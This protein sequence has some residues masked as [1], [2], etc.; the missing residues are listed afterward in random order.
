MKNL[1]K[2]KKLLY[3][4]SILVCLLGGRVNAW[5]TSGAGH[6]THLRTYSPETAK[7][8]VYANT[9]NTANVTNASY[10]AISISES[11]QG[12]GEYK[13]NKYTGGVA[14]DFYGWAK[15]AR[16][17]Q[18]VR[19]DGFNYYSVDPSNATSDAGQEKAASP[20]ANTG[21]ADRIVVSS[22]GGGNGYETWGTAQAVW[23]PATSYTVTYKEPVGGNYTVEYSYLTVNGSNQFVAT[24]EELEL[25]PNSGDKQPY[26]IAGGSQN[27]KSYAT[28]VVTLSTNASNFVG[29]YED[30]VEKSTAKS[31]TY[32]ITKNANIT[33]LFKWIEPV[34]PEEKHIRTTN[35]SADVN[36]SVV[37]SME[38]I[39]ST[40]ATADFTVTLVG[41]T[42]SGTFTL[43]SCSYNATDKELTVPFAYNANGKWDEGSS[44]TIQVAPVN[45]S[46]GTTAS[47]LVKA[48]AQEDSPYQARVSGEGFDTQEGDLTDMLAIAN[49]HTDATLTLLN[50]VAVSS[51]LVVTASMIL[52]LN[53]W[54][55]SSTAANK[56]ISVEGTDTKL[57]IEDNSFLCG[58]E[59]QL[60]R[61]ANS[62]IAA[63]E[64]TGANRLLY[65]QGKMT[66]VNNAEFASNANAKA[67][68]VYVSGTGNAVMQGGSITVES[69]HDARGVFIA[70]GNATLNVG[71]IEAVAKANAYALY[72][73]GKI[74][75][76]EGI[77]LTATTTSSNEAAA[78][79]MTGGTAV[80]D[81]VTMTATSAGTNAY[82]AKV[83]GGK[84]TLNGVSIASTAVTSHAYGVYIAANGNVTIQQQ[85]NITAEVT[86]ASGTRAYGIQNLG[87]LILKNSTVLATSKTY[88]TA[89]NSET[90]A[91]STTIE[92]GTYTAVAPG[93][94]AYG[95]HHQYGALN[96]DGGTF[97][98]TS[99]GDAALAARAAKDATI[100]NA[101]MIAETTG[102]G[103]TA[104][105]FT[106]GVENINVSLTNCTIKAKSATSTADAIY[107]C[108]NVT[109][110]G[111]TLEAKTL[112]GAT[113]H[114]FYAE[115]G[116]NVLTNTNATVESYTTGA[117]GVNF[118]AGTLTV[119]GSTYNVTAKQEPATGAADSEAYG[120]KVADGKT[121]NLTNVIFN[122]NAAKLSF[123]QKAYGV[124]TGTG[125]I[126][127]T[128]CTYTVSA[129]SQV[130][131]IY[132]AAFSSLSLQNN[133][134]SATTT[135]S[136]TAN[137]IYSNGTFAVNGDK[138]TSQTQTYDSYALCLGSSAHGTVHGGKFK[139]LGV[140]TAAN[141]LVAPINNEASASNVHVQGGFFNS[142]VQLRY[143]VPTGYDIYG[144]DP[145]VSEYADGYY[146]TVNDHLPYENV[147]HI[148]EA[149]VGF[150]SL[151]E[152][153]DY[154]RN[155]SG[156]NYNI[157]MTQPYTL[158]AGNYSLPANATLVVPDKVSRTSAQGSIPD[159]R[160]NVT[161]LI[162]ENRLLT[163]ASGVN[164]DVYG[165]LEVSAQQYGNYQTTAYVLGPY[166]RIHME[167]GSTVTLNSGA[168]IYAWGYIT[169]QGEI[170][171]K[172]GA[173]VFE[174]FQVHDMKAPS[175]L[176]SSY[177]TTS[178][179]STYKVFPVNQYYIQNVEAPTKYY[180]GSKLT[181]SMCTT[182]G[183]SPST[184]NVNEIKLVGTNGCLFQVTTNDEASW[185]LKKYDP[186]TDRIIW[187]TNSSAEL[188]SMKIDMSGA[189][190][191]SKDYFLPLTNNMTIHA[192]T[193]LFTITQSTV[194]L[195]GMEIIIDKAATLHI[196]DEDVNGDAMG[197]YLYDK[198]QWS[199]DA[200]P[201]L[202]SPS[203][204]NGT[205]PRDKTAS[206][207]KDAAIYVKGKIEVAG[208]IY[209][210]AGGAAIYSDNT[211]AG[212]IEFSA[213]A[214]ADR[215]LYKKSDGSASVPV[216]S[217]K[218]RNGGETGS[219]AN[220]T[221][222]K[223]V[224]TDDDTY[225]YTNIDGTGFKWT[226][227]KTIDDCTI[228]DA[229]DPAQPVY[230]AKPQG[231]VAITSDTEDVNH[232]FYSV[233]GEGDAKRKFINMPTDAG[234]QWWEVT[235][236]GETSVYYCATNDTYYEYSDMDESWVV[237]KRTV[238]FYFTD[239]KSEDADKKKVLTVNY[240]A[241]PDVSI[242]SNPSKQE[243]AAA[244]YQFRGW[245][246]SETGAEHAYTATNYEP[247]TEN[248]TYYLPV[249]D[250]I[251]KK[252]TIT[253][254]D[255]KNGTNVPVEV[256]YGS[257]P[258]YE[259]KKDPTA[260]YTYYFL[261]WTDAS[262]NTYALDDEL[263]AVTCA[264]TYTAHWAQVVNKY[265]IIWKN[266]EEVLQTDTKQPFGTATA[267]TGTLP[268]K[269]MDDNFVYTFSG[270]RSSL[271]G[272]TYANG[273]TPNVA[274]ETT[275][276]AQ[277][278]TTPRYA[279]T[280]A[281]YDGTQLQKEAVTAGVPPVYNG[282]TP[283]RARDFDG[284]Y[285]FTGW[286]NTNG[287]FYDANATLP[288][289]TAKE[290]YTAQ[291]EYVTELYLITLNNIDG[292][293]GTWSGK[294]GVGSTP[295]YDPNND[296]VA[297]M[298]TKAGNAQYSYPFTGWTPALE[299]VLGEATY[300]AQFGQEINSYT[301]TFANLDGNGASQEV[302]VEYGQTPVC[303]VGIDE[304]KKVVDHTTYAFI[305]WNTAI[306]PVSG[307]AIYMAQFSST[308]TVETFP[309]TFDLDN[310]SDPVVKNV[311]YNTLP[312]I[313]N[314]TKDP[315]EAFTYMFNRWEPAIVKATE[316]ATYTAQYTQTLNK[317]T[318]RFVNYDGTELQSS[319]LAYGSTPTY[320]GEN[321]KKPADVANRK[322]YTFDGWSS[323]NGGAKLNT[324][325]AVNGAATYYV[326]YS[327]AT[328]V[329]SVKH[330]EDEV[331]K[332]S[333]SSAYTDAQANDIIKLYDNL[334]FNAAISIDKNLT[335]DLNGH[336]MYRTGNST[337]A[338]YLIQ[339]S[340]A[341]VSLTIED[342]HGGGLIH[343]VN[344][345]RSSYAI[346]VS[347]TA[348]VTING[349][350]IK[351]EKQNT[352]TNASRI[353]VG[354]YLAAA[355]ARLYINGGE[356]IGTSS[357]GN[358]Y[359]VSHYSTSYGY[360]TVTGGKLKAKTAIFQNPAAARVT[361][362][363]GYY[364]LDPGN[365][366]TIAS[367]YEKW[368]VGASEP[369]KAD[370]Y[371]K[372]VVQVYTITFQNYD[373]TNLET[374]KNWEVG[375]IPAYTGATPAKEPQ[376]LYTFIGWK[377]TND[378]FF[379][380]DA[381]LPAVA[382]DETY[383]AQFDEVE[384]FDVDGDTPVEVDASVETT[385]VT[386]SGKLNVADGVTLTTTNLILEASKSA[387]GQ[388]IE[389]GTITATNVYYDLT[390]NTDARHWHAFGVPWAVDLNTNPLTEVET[391]R[392]L[393]ISRD[394][395]IM[396][397]DGA[398][399]AANGPSA[400]CWK[401]LRHYDEAGQP[402]E[403]LQPGRGYMIAFGSHVNTVRFVKKSGAPIIYTGSVGV[404]AHQIGA[405]SNPMAYH[406]TMDA[407]VGVGQVHD[408]G[409]IGHDGYDEVTITAKRFVVG[410]TVYI[411]PQSTQSVVISK[412]EGGV[413]PVAAPARRGAKVMNKKYL[414]LEDYYTVALI[415]ANG[416]ER[417]VYVL[418][419]EDKEDKYVVGHD[420][421]KMGMSD[422]KAQIWINRYEVNLGLNTTAPM[423][424]VA[425]FPVS[426]Y[427]PKAGEY[428]MSL[429]S[430]P[431]EE[432]TVYLTLNGE[433][434]WNLSSSE[435]AVELAAG[436]NKSYGL[437]LV[438]NK[439]PQTATGIDEAVVDAQGKTRKVI[440][441]DK[442]FIIR[443]E[444]V[445]SVDGQLVK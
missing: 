98:A 309:I 342:S 174:D 86:S 323:T 441:N 251:A 409:E 310:G 186:V 328:F 326:H 101:T 62:A 229:T 356:V 408:G 268:T 381:V 249:F 48:I 63:I 329:A 248:G 318:V 237:V 51:P 146:Y 216:T 281:N 278:S 189:S 58:P 416:E 138:I 435:Y 392:T 252:Y 202:Y 45:A 159:R 78:L 422:R 289:V 55:L 261:N 72:S 360:T 79:Y 286:K 114:G 357:G 298:P 71:K 103:T 358:N 68:A 432:Y 444:N 69:D 376:S 307:E 180:Y 317:Y 236:V 259:P 385:T 439:A 295:F 368:D 348:N 22:W 400:A 100:A 118:V 235:R 167:A 187:E 31:Y 201:I 371:V 341:N 150:P 75:V 137:G 182:N 19:W 336:T 219:D 272:T 87:T 407:G 230:Y 23:E 92:G 375:T 165:K 331:Y 208:A 125:T 322:V 77:S 288:G 232:L 266:G 102:S 308:G 36:E 21:T 279:I 128:G 136:I 437:R 206:S 142:I 120:V 44:V 134:I 117:Y 285:R 244:T 253:F 154:A 417:K 274:G 70:S 327:E 43:G 61:S 151:E 210:T 124:Y 20:K 302:V 199:T 293:G 188:G 260:Q 171:V 402:V 97:T 411:D 353:G 276:E 359:A 277:F 28:D 354:V 382:A 361:L 415:N 144:V 66:V 80:V 393:N 190:M 246:Y 394:Y 386:V 338:I 26:G 263:P 84:L 339:M 54:K 445:Y 233:E 273:S 116:N 320:S 269:E 294:F 373:G 131:G 115:N 363:G 378:V 217:A 355:N 169:G 126:N 315:D 53:N 56:I 12:Q 332:T 105:G 11:L 40:W 57:T 345:S 96:V 387:S 123:S 3:F 370:G 364:S 225:A 153:F 224:A 283:G 321:P 197:L 391:G 367:G 181:G 184:I 7:G 94:H 205:C 25:T 1:L 42:G 301:I 127:S 380:S 82:G 147:C 343:C 207:M 104:R 173:T 109:A 227:L 223:G 333:W 148:T 434:I 292:N 316:P 204:D 108:A 412:A 93:N 166:G 161:E 50:S 203:W 250:T 160:G 64:V 264:A 32:P 95:L 403:V 427:A 83:S 220:M 334:T 231:Y 200:S 429:V 152:A 284:Y 325:P 406:T 256:A 46:Y 438:A 73:G 145:A 242:V 420:L 430:E 424:G 297:D 196:N 405:I 270:W 198:S 426:V 384:I 106:A 254:N 350:I 111:C 33:A 24:P 5:A 362:S 156:T 176:A 340:T 287:D 267:F 6:Y 67:Y 228:A 122:V 234:C 418:P 157:V 324:L 52:D 226:R 311:A 4:L 37:F 275:Y 17:Y 428:T 258:S 372:K 346:Y 193:G 337:S 271:T 291:Y 351:G 175:T 2:M 211:N 436:T 221:I 299:P 185:V 239:P 243:D 413:S 335:I 139:A 365:S 9:S 442:V 90:S 107:S 143:Y 39:I 195:P 191:D 140:S 99:V 347:Q 245:K 89:V 240:G 396:Y 414:T 390:L 314:P 163:F 290:T 209:S 183:A 178:N 443:G 389:G 34:A 330:G 421:S 59:I 215:T 319:E 213:N 218:L 76:A 65:K 38:N 241:K 247:V 398:E 401:Y 265:T 349:G 352:S 47:V 60:T 194:M 222:T 168:A 129:A 410:K 419:E 280:F 10:S 282:L 303:P 431:D 262:S 212:T 404:T 397:Y 300:T 30:G 119:E 172:N 306:V 121:A 113:A 132:G 110:T 29:W 433:A 255:A 41:A 395:E 304:I 257:H 177:I 425:E 399:R 305:G 135:G 440:I 91:I 170:R 15:P 112:S 238:T 179:K 74:N 81:N 162:L 312:V 130:Y 383:T 379:A 133:I 192:L 369:E 158:P 164:L 344:T 85:A 141:Q 18:F 16:G 8:L 27:G 35:N 423:D 313:E 214:A 88:P 296:D 49:A 366:V 374:P 377:N 388:I 14:L 149:N 13:N 155:H